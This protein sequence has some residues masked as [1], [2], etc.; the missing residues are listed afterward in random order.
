MTKVQSGERIYKTPSIACAIDTRIER[1]KS[2]GKRLKTVYE[3]TEIKKEAR[4]YVVKLLGETFKQQKLVII[5]LKVKKEI[6]RPNNRKRKNEKKEKRE[7]ESSG[8]SSWST[9]FPF[10]PFFTTHNVPYRPCGLLY[11]RTYVRTLYTCRTEERY[12]LVTHAC[13]SVWPTGATGRRCVRA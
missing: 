9:S 13:T 3:S 5:T 2:A 7:R 11:V 4:D 1:R 8:E 6:G 12:K 10:S